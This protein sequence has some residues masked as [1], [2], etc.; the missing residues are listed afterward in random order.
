MRIDIVFDTICPWCFIGKRQ[1]DLALA[2][3][4]YLNF[5]INWYSY[6]LNPEMPLEG[7][8]FNEYIHKKLGGKLKYEKLN[9]AIS[10]SAKNLKLKFDLTRIKRA[11][12]TLN[13]HRLIKL[14]SRQN[15]G[16][17]M[18]EALYQNY[19]VKGRDIGNRSVLIDIGTELGFDD[20]N[21]RKYLY[22][23]KDIIETLSQNQHVSRLGVNGVPAF[24]FNQEFSISGVQDTK[25]L[26]RMLNVAEENSNK[27]HEPGVHSIHSSY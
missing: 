27:I 15:Q 7:I 13:S 5:E 10:Q 20:I 8:D 16:A 22:G 26:M 21:L 2:N 12:N 1:L 11:P 23:D 17:E 24:I 9:N 18:L 3:L 25:V 19:F 14:A 6:F 4:P